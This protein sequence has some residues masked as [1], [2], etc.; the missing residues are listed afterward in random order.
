MKSS[1]TPG[2]PSKATSSSTTGKTTTTDQTQNGNGNTSTTGTSASASAA[3]SSAKKPMQKISERCTNLSPPLHLVM[4]DVSKYKTSGQFWLSDG[5]L[6]HQLGYKLSLAVK[7]EAGS[8]ENHTKVTLALM[9]RSAKGK[10]SPYLDYPCVGSTTVIILNPD[11]KSN[12][13]TVDFMFMLQNQ[14]PQR[15]SY[16]ELNEQTE[17]ADSF[18]RKDCI[19]FRIEK[20]EMSEKPY[21]L[22]LLDPQNYN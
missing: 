13:E 7:L 3:K 2:K 16:P 12:H 8:T 18:I 9:S 5:L 19:F 21:R 17:I 10:R 4:E 11:N 1:A 14:E 20:V 6:S 15:S 22:W